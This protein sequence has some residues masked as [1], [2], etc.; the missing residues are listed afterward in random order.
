[1]AGEFPLPRRMGPG[2]RGYAAGNL[3]VDEEDRMMHL[4]LTSV[5]WLVKEVM[6]D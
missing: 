1:M 6:Q 2:T 4:C 5:F 3:K